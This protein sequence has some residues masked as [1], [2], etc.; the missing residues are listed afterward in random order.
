MR[1]GRRRSVARIGRQHL[2][3]HWQTRM[4]WRRDHPGVEWVALGLR[5]RRTTDR[6]L[7]RSASS[8]VVERRTTRAGIAVGDSDRRASSIHQSSPEVD[9]HS[10]ASRS[11]L[12]YR[13]KSK[14]ARM[15]II[16]RP[17]SDV[18]AKAPAATQ[19]CAPMTRRAY[20]SAS[21]ARSATAAS[22]AP[23]MIARCAALPQ[24]RPG[25]VG[26]PGALVSLSITRFTKRRIDLVRTT[27]D[28]P[29]S[30]SPSAKVVSVAAI[31]PSDRNRSQAR[32]VTARMSAR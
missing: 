7:R 32:E 19:K 30:S 23:P 24:N 11:D 17:S 29:Y 16:A 21:Y 18:A 9:A 20:A 8:S 6:P 5:R 25:D 14:I 27:A 1:G 10:N 15:S 13:C 26:R 28:F 4:A 31:C 3:H 22:I 12:A 2:R